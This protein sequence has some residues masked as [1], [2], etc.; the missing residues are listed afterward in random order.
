MIWAD[1]AGLAIAALIAFSA[2]LF[3][4]VLFIGV[5]S[6]TDGRLNTT[7]L[8][9]TAIAEIAVALPVWVV[10]RLLDLVFGGPWRRRARREPRVERTEPD[11]RDF[12]FAGMDDTA[13][14]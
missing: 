13:A 6:L 12:D 5:G 11:L 3:T 7:M 1:R 9:W 14:D 8:L 10:L 4:I 2:G